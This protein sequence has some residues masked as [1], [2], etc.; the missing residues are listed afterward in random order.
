MKLLF[1]CMCVIVLIMFT[2][3]VLLM[4]QSEAYFSGT[5]LLNP[6]ERV[7]G[8][9]MPGEAPILGHSYEL[10]GEVSL[11]EAPFG[12]Y[13]AEKFVEFF[14]KCI[15]ED[16]RDRRSYNDKLFTWFVHGAA[17]DLLPYVDYEVRGSIRDSDVVDPRE[18]Q[19]GLAYAIQSRSDVMN[20]S[21]I[22]HTRPDHNIGI[23]E[24]NGPLMITDNR[25]TLHAF[26]GKRIVHITPRSATMPR[27]QR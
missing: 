1:L 4:K 24:P 19:P 14:K 13:A 26:R 3:P 22:G 18:L 27:T 17:V 6:P 9:L 5:R 8:V 2:S 11:E 10:T 20:H 15:A 16:P 7:I 23:M 12:Q 25:A 21:M